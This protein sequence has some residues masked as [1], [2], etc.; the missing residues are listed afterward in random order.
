[1]IMAT[2][3]LILVFILRMIYGELAAHYFEVLKDGILY[4][5]IAVGILAGLFAL[6]LVSV[7]IRRARSDRAPG[8]IRCTI[9]FAAVLAFFL[10]CELMKGDFTFLQSYET[11]L[12]IGMAVYA[13]FY[14]LMLVVTL[15]VRI[16]GGDKLRG[17]DGDR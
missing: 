4:A 14:V 10:V 7:L 2:L 16:R 5:D 12:V 15:I 13:L 3:S 17:E 9:A 6:Y 8:L 11:A 1:M